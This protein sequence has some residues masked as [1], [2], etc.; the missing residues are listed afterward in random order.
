[1]AAVIRTARLSLVPASA[2]LAA[3]DVVGVEELAGLLGA[4]VP[5]SWPPP[6]VDDARQF[7]AE[8]LGEH[9]DEEGW[10]LWYWLVPDVPAASADLVGVGGFKGPPGEDGTAEI[11]YSLLPEHQLRGYA[12]E[13]VAALI[14]HAFGRREVR[15]I[16]AETFFHLPR[17]I[18]VLVRNGFVKIDEPPNEPDALRFELRRSRSR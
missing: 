13:A 9:P 10:W 17:S 2:R 5:A 6:L 3:A 7:F 11:G 12:T 18:R 8:R 15:R 14:R 16:I 1:L 4:R